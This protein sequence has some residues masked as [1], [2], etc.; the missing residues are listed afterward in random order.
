MQS[1]KANESNSRIAKGNITSHLTNT[2][3]YFLKYYEQN[4]TQM[5][6][7]KI[8][9]KMY[10]IKTNTRRNKTYHLSFIIEEL[11]QHLKLSLKENTAK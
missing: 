5:Q 2:E 7:E 10:F 3:K 8:L 1:L 4:Y 11:N 9:E 6:A